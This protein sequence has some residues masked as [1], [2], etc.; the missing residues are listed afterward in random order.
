MPLLVAAASAAAA[1]AAAGERFVA[2]TSDICHDL[3]E[4]CA[5][6]AA[7]GECERNLS[8][9][10]LYACRISC[11]SCGLDVADVSPIPVVEPEFMADEASFARCKARIP[12]ERLRWGADRTAASEVGCSRGGRHE[13]K[14]A[15]EQTGLVKA[16]ARAAARDES[17]TFYDTSTGV[18]LFVAPR[19]RTMHHFLQESRDMGWL[20]F[21]DAEVELAHVRTLRATRGML[22]SADGLRIGV[23]QPDEYTSRY[24]INIA[25]IAGRP[26]SPD[27]RQQRDEL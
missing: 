18:P 3:H 1:I 9:M 13:L 11:D 7:A 15:W 5:A 2:G 16:A 20:V 8:Y 19:N 14:G 23:N 24:I 26:P 25:T 17:I 6:W 27:G 12:R 10:R 22:V 4:S 21:R